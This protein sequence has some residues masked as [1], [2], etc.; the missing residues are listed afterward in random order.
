MLNA[1]WIAKAAGGKLIRPR[2][3]TIRGFSIDSRSLLPGQVFVALRG[4][5]ADGHDHV[6]HA[7]ERG[8]GAALVDRPKLADDKRLSDLILVED[9]QRALHAVARTYRA[10]FQV[11]LIGITGSVGKTTT[12][13]LLGRMLAQRFKAYHSPGNFNN[14]YGLPLS[15]LNMPLGTEIAAFELAAQRPG[16]IQKLARLLDP[17]VGVITTVADAHLGFYDSHDQLVREKW[18][19]IEE[20]PVTSG[21]VV[22]N[23]DDAQLW[24]RPTGQRFRVDFAIKRPGAPYRA[25]ELEARGAEGTAF[26]LVH[27]GGRTRI[28]T[29]LIGVHNV[30]NVLAAAA[31]ALE[32]RVD[33]AGVQRAAAAFAPSPHRLERKETRFG[34]LLD[35]C[36]N[37][38]PS[39]VRASLR[40]LGAMGDGH[41]VFVFGDMLELGE[42][43]ADYH[44]QVAQW[45]K[46]AGVERVFTLGPLAAETATALQKQHGWPPERARASRTLEELE[47]ALTSTLSRDDHLILVKGSRGLAL[48]RLVDKLV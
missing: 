29:S 25:E 43:A 1:Q 15:V 6:G 42:R 33:P 47:G 30:Y 46:E 34:L 16:D 35:D 11:P 14:E 13:E 48:E 12:K 5:R 18:S 26:T 40:A 31:V 24:N 38:S 36:Y 32:M 7:F 27:P 4:E 8:A 44:R 10:L 39:A 41:K 17:S 20:L 45:I 2:R 9:T 37:A 22:L 19:L 23:A 21:I 3:G 28:E